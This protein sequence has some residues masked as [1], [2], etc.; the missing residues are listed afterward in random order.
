MTKRRTDLT[1]P[2]PRSFGRLSR[3]WTDHPS[4]EHAAA[5]VVDYREAALRLVAYWA[6]QHPAEDWESLAMDGLYLAAYTFRPG[7]TCFYDWLQRLVFHAIWNR[8][9][10]VRCNSERLHRVDPRILEELPFRD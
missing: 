9:R 10:I 2:S 5:L 8:K 7:P 3:A 1:G 6:R 4:P